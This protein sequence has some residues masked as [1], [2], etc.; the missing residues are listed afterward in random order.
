[1]IMLAI[2]EEDWQEE[3]VGLGQYS[4]NEKTLVA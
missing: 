2:K 1:M 4:I 3:V